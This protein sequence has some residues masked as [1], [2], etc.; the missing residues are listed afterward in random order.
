MTL[1]DYLPQR[2]PVPP[3]WIASMHTSIS[4]NDTRNTQRTPFGRFIQLPRLSASFRTLKCQ[5][6]GH[7]SC[8]VAFFALLMHCATAPCGV[9]VTTCTL[10]KPYH[11][12]TLSNVVIHSIRDTYIL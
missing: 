12:H 3:Y 1:W 6:K 7:V 10:S 9:Q 2:H 5:I 11:W 4:K 8:Y